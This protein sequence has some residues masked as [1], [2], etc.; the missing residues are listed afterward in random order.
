MAW[1]K[2]VTKAFYKGDFWDGEGVEEERG[3]WVPRIPLTKDDKISFSMGETRTSSIIVSDDGVHVL[4]QQ[5]C[6][7]KS[8]HIRYIEWYKIQFN[9]NK[10]NWAHSRSEIRIR[11]NWGV[12]PRCYRTLN[13]GMLFAEL[14]QKRH[15]WSTQIRMMNGD[16]NWRHAI[17]RVWTI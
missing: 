1:I 5:L 12:G 11:W 17:W 4:A 6:L 14:S 10:T 13:T 3:K 8:T 9:R 2:S 16:V 15:A 7:K